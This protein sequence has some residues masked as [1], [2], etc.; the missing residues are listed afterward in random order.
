MKILKVT[1]A[2]PTQ[3]GAGVKIKRIAGFD[4]KSIDPFLMIDELK[5]DNAQDYIGGFPPHP[6]RGIETFTYIR[7]G[8][9]EHQDQMGNKKAIRAGEVQWMST[10]RGV[11]HSEMPLAD[12]KYGMHGFQIWLNMPAR[13]KMDPPKYQDSSERALPTLTTAQG[14]T[15]KALAGEWSVGEKTISSGL[16]DLSGEGAISDITLP[17]HSSIQLDLSHFG[18]V[19]AYIHSGSLKDESHQA[20]RLLTLDAKSPILIETAEHDAGLLLLAGQP[21]NE[22][23][24]HMGPFVMNTQAELQQAVRD[25]HAGLFGT[26]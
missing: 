26:L 15:L 11:V 18:K 22:K 12:A 24:A 23:I 9:F 8:G 4:G 1:K 20:G 5:S 7:Q 17:K 19:I 3:D 21:I 10:G 6:H 16:N 13:H 14:A 2:Q 25:Y